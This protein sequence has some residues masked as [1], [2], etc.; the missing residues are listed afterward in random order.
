MIV[1]ELLIQYISP[2]RSH[3]HLLS[4][5]KFIKTWEQID[6]N[7]GRISLKHGNEL[8]LVFAQQKFERL[9]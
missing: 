5:Y 6:Q 2:A 3:V 9:M 1:P 8:Y 7:M 4:A